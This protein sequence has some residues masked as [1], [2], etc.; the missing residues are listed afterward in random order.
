[1]EISDKAVPNNNKKD[2]KMLSCQEK[3]IVWSTSKRLARHAERYSR[4]VC[5]CVCV[6]VG[7]G[8]GGVII[9]LGRES[10]RKSKEPTL[11]KLTDI[12]P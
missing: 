11:P 1:M 2:I 10:Q 8:G 7:G 9:H 3:K 4:C 6:C 5:A 12:N